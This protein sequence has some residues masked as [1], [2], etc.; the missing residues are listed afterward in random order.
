VLS[1]QR[2][3][4]WWLRGAAVGADGSLWD[5]AEHEQGRERNAEM[6]AMQEDSNKRTEV[7]RRVVEEQIQEER[8]RTAEQLAEVE[9][10]TLRQK[11]LFEADARIKVL[12]RTL[13]LRRHR[14]ST[15]T[16]HALSAA[17]GCRMCMRRSC[18]Q[19]YLSAAACTKA[20][21]R[22]ATPFTPLRPRAVLC[23]LSQGLA[24]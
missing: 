12:K 2:T 22:L 6:V 17:C 10:E 14:G 9:R 7:H 21:Q 5:Q 4:T 20:I 13:A 1:R 24:P 18:C 8:R 11:S 23:Q 16:D 15:G 19:R 3:L